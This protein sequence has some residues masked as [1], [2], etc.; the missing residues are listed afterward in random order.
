MVCKLSFL[1]YSCHHQKNK[2]RGS[3]ILKNLDFGKVKTSFFKDNLLISLSKDWLA[4]NEGK[5]LVFE[6]KL[7]K[8]GKL[9]LSASLAALD[10][11]KEVDNVEM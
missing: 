1:S 2:C 10:S 8:N 5:P 11:S 4:I 7:T 6:A 9:E 3:Y